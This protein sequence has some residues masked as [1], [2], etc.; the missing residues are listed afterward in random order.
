MPYTPPA[1]RSPAAS[2]PT[3]PVLSRAASH[4]NEQRSKDSIPQH[5]ST[6]NPSRSPSS[7]SYLSRHRRS[8]S[9]TNPVSPASDTG[10][11]TPD[12]TPLNRSPDTEDGC[13]TEASS[14]AVR[15]AGSNQSGFSTEISPPVSPQS[16]SDEESSNRRG[17]SRDVA[18]LAE[19]QAAIQIIEQ[20]RAGSP[21]RPQATSLRKQ[22]RLTLG[23]PDPR[24][25]LFK[26]FDGPPP[27]TSPRPPLSAGARKISHSRS[28]TDSSA[29]FDFPRN[30]F[31]SPGQSSSPSD[32]EDIE[33]NELRL[34]PA[35]IRKKSGELVRPALRASSMKRRPSSA[36]GTPTYSKA[37]HFQE[38][39]MEHVRHFL[40][41]DRPIAVSAGSSPQDPY[42][43]DTEYPFDSDE[44]KS[45]SSPYQWE[46]R[47]S[48]FPR[49]SI[50]RRLSPVWTEKIYLSADTK[51]LIGSVVVR[52]LAF[53][54]VVVARFTLDYWKTTSE[55]GAEYNTDVRKKDLDPD[56]D[57]FTFN[58]KLEDQANLETKTMLFCVRYHVNGQDYWDNND[59]ANYQIDFSKKSKPQDKKAAYQVQSSRP[60][61]A[62]PRS[63][64]SASFSPRPRSMPSFDDFAGMVSPYDFSSFP[65]PSALI[66]DSP[67]RFKTKPSP[68]GVFPDAPGRPK[69][70]SS[71]QAF[72]NRYDF[73]ASLSAAM[74]NANTAGGERDGPSAKE[75]A[76]D[77]KDAAKVAS[78][79]P[80]EQTAP[81]TVQ[82]VKEAPP[83][84]QD[85]NAPL[86]PAALTSAKPSL[87]STSYHELLDKYCFVRSGHS[88]TSKGLVR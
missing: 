67:I 22:A 18:N 39:S 50:E 20:H 33:D 36:P 44:S 15:A 25:D 86:K 54:K 43:S 29:F 80:G 13:H 56:Y 34:K 76:T 73:G 17:R 68:K 5:G 84:K 48:N 57:R 14:G 4:H 70:S 47:L 82:P 64:P 59:S 32:D 8:P 58:I 77:S 6:N 60:L 9:I 35:L 41:V 3:S 19:L 12:A 28:S 65:Q 74:Q 11:S 51:V 1:A 24:I 83:T 31:D 62:L 27:E 30:K 2:K 23:L 52:N 10:L 85:S 71:Q 26:S 66:G 53:H 16:S 45:N 46:I 79:A 87:S 40:Q 88:T 49:T 78:S 75:T 7:R 63:R 38:N 21:D 72:G 69:E 42:D 61:N 55:V 37:V 81:D